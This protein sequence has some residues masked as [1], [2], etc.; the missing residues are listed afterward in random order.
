MSVTLD[1]GTVCLPFW[2]SDDLT[3]QFAAKAGDGVKFRKAELGK[4]KGYAKS[5]Q[6]FLLLPNFL[7][8]A[9]DVAV[10]S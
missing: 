10:L 6:C 5:E 4:L 7:V 9:A 1:E 3:S 2:L 8:N